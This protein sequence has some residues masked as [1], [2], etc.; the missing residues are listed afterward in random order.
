MGIER[1]AEIEQMA[2]RHIFVAN[3]SAFVLELVRELLQNERYNVTST[4][5]VPNTL[6]Q[7]AV[8]APDLLVVDLALGERAGWDLLDRLQGEAMTRGVPVIVFSADP[9]LLERART[10][11]P[12]SGTRRY[13]AKPF[14]L[15][16][17]LALVEELIGPA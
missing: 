9:A 11:H 5:Y 6:E 13:L 8:L 14:H 4:N 16:T 3:S 15:S 17:L 2:R 12:P 10:A 1:D 7:I